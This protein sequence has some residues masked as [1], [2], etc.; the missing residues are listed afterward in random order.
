MHRGQMLTSSAKCA[1]ACCRSPHCRMLSRGPT[2]WTNASQPR[3]GRDRD[4]DNNSD[5]KETLPLIFMV[6][7]IAASA[8][9]GEFV[10][11]KTSRKIIGWPIGIVVFVLLM[12]AYGAATAAP[13]SRSARAE[14]QRF[15][16]CP[17][18]GKSRGP[19]PGYIIDHVTPLACGGPNLPSNMQWQTITDAKAKDRW[20]RIGCQPARINK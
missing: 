5:V 18:T 8:S 6:I 1:S 13:R 4:L 15:M 17:S 10:S 19:C 3:A 2:G 16:P 20:E 11:R 9:I 7:A 14:F 12:A